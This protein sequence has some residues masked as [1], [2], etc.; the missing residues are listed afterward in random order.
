MNLHKSGKKITSN[1][2]DNFSNKS[3]LK[4]LG[5]AIAQHRLQKWFKIENGVYNKY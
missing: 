2:Y 3:M 4:I 1:N 5:F